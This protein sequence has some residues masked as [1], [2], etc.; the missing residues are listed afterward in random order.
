MVYLAP[1]AAPGYCLMMLAL[2]VVKSLLSYLVK[3]TQNLLVS[4]LTYHTTI[5][6]LSASESLHEDA[7][8]SKSSRNSRS[9]DS[10]C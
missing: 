3:V 4:I 2:K 6:H 9:L 10:H 1:L 5:L 8:S 7:R